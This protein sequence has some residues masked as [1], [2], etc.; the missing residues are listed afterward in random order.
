MDFS[1]SLRVLS[2]F[3]QKILSRKISLIFASAVILYK[4]CMLFLNQFYTHLFSDDL[5]H[6]VRSKELDIV[7]NSFF[8]LGVEL[9][10]FSSILLLFTG[11]LILVLVAYKKLGRLHKALGYFYFFMLFPFAIPGAVLLV[12]YTFGS[13]VSK[14]AFYFVAALWFFTGIQALRA[15]LR[16]NIDE[17]KKWICLN[18]GISLSAPAQRSLVNIFNSNRGIFGNYDPVIFYDLVTIVSFLIPIIIA[19]MINEGKINIRKWDFKNVLLASVLVVFIFKPSITFIKVFFQHL[20]FKDLIKFVRTKDLEIMTNSYFQ[21]GVD[22]HIFSSVLLLF[23]G[24][25]IFVL[26]AFKIFGKVHKFLGY[27][28]FLMLFPFAIPGAILLA[29]FSFG[30]TFNIGLFYFVILLWLFTGIQALRAI[31]KKEIE[32]HKKFIILNFS[33]TLSA[34]LQRW[35]IKV[36]FINKSYHGLAGDTVYNIATALSFILPIFIASCF[37]LR[38][39]RRRKSIINLNKTVYDNI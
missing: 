9:H 29:P 36:F 1:T 30:T 7:T 2:R 18:I 25:L 13:G 22:L 23:T 32:K 38:N 15:I 17:H 6:F 20:F 12:P 5:I 14:I 27:F 4:P 24:V 28:Y 26:M 8:Q 19:W 35:L 3:S 11:L 39:N 16:K 21:M 37:L 33:I 31:L 34:P 10:I